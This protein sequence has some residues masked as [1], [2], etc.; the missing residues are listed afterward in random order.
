VTATLAGNEP[1][2][3]QPVPPRDAPYWQFYE[4][5]AAAQLAD[6]LPV[7]PCRVLDLSDSHDRFGDQLLA[8]GH[9]V[10]HVV[11]PDEDVAQAAATAAELAD[12]E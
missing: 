11:R 12:D 8:A 10:L 1:A 4:R 6:W 3:G 5:V 7:E 2:G 9:Q